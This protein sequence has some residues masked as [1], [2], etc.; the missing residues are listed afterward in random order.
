MTNGIRTVTVP[1]QIT[2]T[3]GNGIAIT[4]PTPNN[5]LIETE[6]GGV[7]FWGGGDTYIV[8]AALMG[9]SAHEGFAVFCH[10]DL[11]TQNDYALIQSGGTSSY[12]YLNCR[13]GG[14]LVFR[15]NNSGR[16]RL[17]DESNCNM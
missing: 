13:N 15:K 17:R 14:Q 11:N 10:K 1:S 16:M 8:G 7:F 9:D 4:E 6:S 5:F 3:A 12:T 2:L